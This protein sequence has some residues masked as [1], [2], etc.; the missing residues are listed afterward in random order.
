[1]NK[2]EN[3]RNIFWYLSYIFKYHVF[4]NLIISRSIQGWIIQ[5]IISYIILN[6]FS[7][8]Q[9]TMLTQKC[10]VK[11]TMFVY[12]RN[13]FLVSQ[14]VKCLFFVQMEQ[15]LAKLFSPVTGGTYKIFYAILYEDL[16]TIRLMM[17]FWSICFYSFIKYWCIIF[18]PEINDHKF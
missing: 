15:Y 7:L 6:I 9:V 12:L 14:I 18:N 3:I 1:M 16:K 11:V 8:F 13:L 10:S 5:I 2:L 17:W 4:N